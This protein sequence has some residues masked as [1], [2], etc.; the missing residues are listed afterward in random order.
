MILYSER[1]RIDLVGDE[2]VI[3]SDSAWKSEWCV[4]TLGVSFVILFW[5]GIQ[6]SWKFCFLQPPTDSLMNVLD[7]VKTFLTGLVVS[8]ILVYNNV[9][10]DC[11]VF[12]WEHILPLY[13]NQLRIWRTSCPCLWDGELNGHNHDARRYKVKG[14]RSLIFPL[15][16]CKGDRGKCSAHGCNG[17][18]G[19]GKWLYQRWLRKEVAAGFQVLMFFLHILIYYSS[20]WYWLSCST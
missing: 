16:G 4:K 1:R 5:N 12:W 13:S 19:K 17:E 2:E 3:L 6:C 20:M 9:E 18:R 7:L 14:Y 11:V 8:V 15:H 10:L